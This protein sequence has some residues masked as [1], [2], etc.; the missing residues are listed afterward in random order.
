MNTENLRNEIIASFEGNV[1][2][3]VD[4]LNSLDN[5]G[6]GQWIVT[7]D[8]LGIDVTGKPGIGGMVVPLS[9][10]TRFQSKAT[11]QALACRV[12]N[13]LGER[14]KAV[15]LAEAIADAIIDINEQIATLKARA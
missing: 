10:A 5:G 14:G 8:G 2:S 1:R 15:L 13:G 4:T 7:C 3:L 9:Q 6:L 12:V 11:A